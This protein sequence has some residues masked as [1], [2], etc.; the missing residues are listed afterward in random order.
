LSLLIITITTDLSQRQYGDKEG[1]VL[2]TWRGVLEV[3]VG[4]E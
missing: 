1:D 4:T 2:E 3:K